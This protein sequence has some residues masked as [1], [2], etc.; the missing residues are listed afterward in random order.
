MNSAEKINNIVKFPGFVD[1]KTLLQRILESNLDFDVKGINVDPRHSWHPFPAKYPPGLPRIFINTLTNEN[2]IV[3]DP[4][5]GSCTTLIESENLKRQSFGFDID[6]LSLIVGTAKLQNYNQESVYNTGIYI[7]KSSIKKFETESTYLEYQLNNRFDDETK[8]FLDYWFL[9]QTQ[10]ELLSLIIEIEKIKDNA[11]ISFFKMIFSSIIISKSG[12][13][14]L[15]R[16]LAHTRPHRV[17]DKI[18][19]SA[20]TEF[21]KK[22]NKVISTLTYSDNFS[23]RVVL[24]SSNAK[25]LPLPSNSIDLIVTSPPYANNAIDYM[26]AHKFSLVWFGHKISELKIIRR[27][28]VGSENFS[29]NYVVDL[30]LYATT[31]INKLKAVDLAKGKSLQRYYSEMKNVLEE[32]YR[33]LKPNSA[34]VVI[35]ATSVLKGIDVETHVCL[36][37]IGKKIGL[38][39]VGIGE[40]NINR[41]KRMLPTSRDKNDSQIELRMHKEHVIGFFKS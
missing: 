13:V 24:Q 20:F 4:M 31:I 5:M 18:P 37:E 1:K 28:Y 25:Q 30:P 21:Q 7:L 39:L 38:E 16:D 26:R 8:K 33:V 6:P 41:D 32:L 3:L 2:Q 11:L 19:K 12:G 17:N 9:K 15:G 22:I 27:D 14:T 35:V 40:R 34:C 10:L 36:S 23:T 29:E